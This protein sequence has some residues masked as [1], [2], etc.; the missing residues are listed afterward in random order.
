MD[1]IP[2]RLCGYDAP[3]LECPHCEHRSSSPS[4]NDQR[5]GFLQALVDGLRAVPNG[6][7][8]LATTPGTK[9]FLIPPVILTGIAFFVL[10]GWLWGFIDLLV[11]A[12][13]VEDVAS[14]GLEDGW[15]KVAVVWLVE[16]GVAAFVAKW[17][18]VLLWLFV[19]SIAALYAFSIVYEALAGPFLD[20]IQGRIETLWF[21]ANPRDAIE[22]PTDIP[23]RRCV[24][25]S[26][27]A[28]GAAAV[29]L[30]G[31]W[32]ASPLSWWLILP[33]SLLPFFAAAALDREYGRWL[34]W[35]V[36]VEGHLL[37]VSIKA[38]LIVLVLLVMFIWL[39]F[40]PVVGLPLFMA[41]AGFG[42]AI[43]LLDIPFSRRGWSLTRRMQFMVH[44]GGALTAYGVVASLVFLVPVIGPIVMVPAA[45]IGG[46]WL[47]VRLDKDSLRPP[48]LRRPGGR[49]PSA[50]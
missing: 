23:V 45:S 46:L 24:L 41:V 33:L 10:F 34:G 13:E 9:R 4:L 26:A 50:A 25:F 32:I 8:L 28:G 15:L 43:T 18:G 35:V 22:R 40:V 11:E 36:R 49:E 48:E 6:L 29:I 14:I 16:K 27:V 39:K 12:V 30:L 42:T 47:V 20:E 44:N 2:C 37:W 7:F 19:S 17:T 5:V 31:L 3:G 1:A 38:S 21:G